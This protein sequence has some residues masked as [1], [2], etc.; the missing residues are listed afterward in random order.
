MRFSEYLRS[1]DVTPEEL[2]TNFEL[3]KTFV[4]ENNVSSGRCYNCSAVISVEILRVGP[5]LIGQHCRTCASII[6][7]N[8]VN[9]NNNSC[10]VAIYKEHEYTN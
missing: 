2:E 9:V 8:P 4:I 10:K 3:V 6:I 7:V 5:W 1:K